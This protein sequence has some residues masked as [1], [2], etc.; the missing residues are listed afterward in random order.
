M[1]NL[2]LKTIILLIVSAGIFGI[3]CE[4]PKEKDTLGLSDE[5]LGLV[6][7]GF[8][9]N[10]N[11]VDLRDGTVLDKGLNLIWRKCSQGQV[12][13]GNE[14]DC[15]GAVS[16]TLF[17]PNDQVLWGAKKFAYCN[18]NTWSCNTRTVPLTLVA[19]AG[20]IT[21]GFS[22][23]L[24][25]CA[26]LN[27]ANGFPGWRVPT[28]FELQRLTLG[29]RTALLANFPDTVESLYWSSW[30]VQDDTTGEIAITVNFDRESFGEE[31]TVQKI[32]KTYVRC[33]RPAVPT[34]N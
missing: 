34:S 24:N 17:T 4:A 10:T 7:T 3:G 19:N 15:R 33:I 20:F 8:L 6:L 30:S 31:K 2:K 1:N 29:G 12:Y 22:E 26:A 11:L 16:G 21:T 18:T 5:E 23:A 13:R 14:N 9:L 25:T 32:E 28:P 27:D